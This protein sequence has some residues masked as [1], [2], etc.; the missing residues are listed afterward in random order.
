MKRRKGRKQNG[1]KKNEDEELWRKTKRSKREINTCEECLT[2]PFGT[3]QLEI[4][5]GGLCSPH[6]QSK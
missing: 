2:S 5:E 3:G 1:Q 4:L 6:L